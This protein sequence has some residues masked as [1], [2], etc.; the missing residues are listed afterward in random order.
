VSRDPETFPTPDE[1][2]LAGLAHLTGLFLAFLIWT[3]QKDR[4]P[5]VRYQAMQA[6]VFDSIAMALF[7]LFSIGVTAAMSL[8]PFLIVLLADQQGVLGTRPDWF[9]ILPGLLP[10]GSLGILLLVFVLWMSVRL[11]A[12]F[13]VFSGRDFDYPLIR[14]VAR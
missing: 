9:S 10:L 7:I 4:S 11:W 5:F 6:L 8:A 3:K 1:R 13:S 12:A 14:K 2:L